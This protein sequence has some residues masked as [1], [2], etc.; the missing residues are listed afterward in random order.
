MK[1][2]R[3]SVFSDAKPYPTVPILPSSKKWRK[4]IKSSYIVHMA[5][6][7]IGL[8]S[9]ILSSGEPNVAI[10]DTVTIA[11]GCWMLIKLKVLS[12]PEAQKVLGEGEWGQRTRNS[13][14]VNTSS[15]ERCGYQYRLSCL[16]SVPLLLIWESVKISS[17]CGCW[18]HPGAEWHSCSQLLNRLK[19]GKW[20]C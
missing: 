11:R 9:R 14:F 18:E 8:S 15:L 16:I 2:A 5:V 17:W 4:A 6:L 20:T 3:G 12:D 7:P 1:N 19:V 10:S 13:Q